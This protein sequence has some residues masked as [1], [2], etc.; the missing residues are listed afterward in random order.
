M[1]M[2]NPSTVAD[3]WLTF[4]EVLLQLVLLCVTKWILQPQSHGQLLCNSQVRSQLAASE[5]SVSSLK[6]EL[7]K[8]ELQT[9]EFASL[10]Q[11]LEQAE[12]GKR[13]MAQD[14]QKQQA[15]L[16]G[17]LQAAGKNRDQFAEQVLSCPVF[18]LHTLPQPACLCLNVVASGQAKHELGLVV[19][20]TIT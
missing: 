19:Q 4:P 10:Q 1:Y 16:E 5:T 12:Q 8:A 7:L 6:A 2:L 14:W 17:Q 13:A 9:K 15:L 3:C 11:A 18:H 20:A